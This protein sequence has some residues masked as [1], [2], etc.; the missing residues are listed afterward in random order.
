MQYNCY[1]QVTTILNFQAATFSAEYHE[2][3]ETVA[4]VWLTAQRSYRFQKS[5]ASYSLHASVLLCSG[6]ELRGA[7]AE[8]GHIPGE[9]VLPKHPR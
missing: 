5:T 9:V 6:S 7:R 8:C 1:A 4:A 3:T 2:L